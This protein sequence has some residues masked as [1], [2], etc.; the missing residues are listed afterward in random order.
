LEFINRLRS[1]GMKISEMKEYT[2]LRNMGDAT[3]TERKNILEE[4]LDSIDSEIKKLSEVRNYVAMKI[5]IYKK[6]EDKIN[7]KG[8]QITTGV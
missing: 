7:G 5:E 1:T 8:Q 6:M 3:I 2:R 4:H